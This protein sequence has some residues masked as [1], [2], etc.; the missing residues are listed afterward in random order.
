MAAPVTKIYQLSTLGFDVVDKQLKSIAKD[1]DAIKKAKKSAEGGLTAA[2]DTGD[3]DG[4]KKFREELQKLKI[5]EQELRVQRQQM[6]NEQKA[7]NI[8]RQAAIQAEKERVKGLRDASGWYGKLTTDIRELGAAIKNVQ[9][10]GDVVTFRGQQ[11]QFDAAI[12]KLQELTAAEQAFRR[13]FAADRTLVGEYTTGIVNAF[14]QMGL[15]DLIAGQVTRTQDKLNSLNNEFNELQRELKETQAAG[16]ATNSIEKQMIDN[17][18]EVI[19]LDTELSR[20][21]TDLRGVGDVGNQINASLK[22]GFSQVK[23]QLSSLLVQYLGV[24][25]AISAAQSGIQDA[26]LSSDQFTDLEIQ[27]NNDKVAADKLNTALKE[28]DTR[29]T[30]TGLQAIADV[31]L[32][33]GV[34]SENIAAVTEAIDK[35]KVAFG[36][37]FGSVEQGTETFAKLINIFFD[38]GQITG[39]RILKIGNSI[40]SLANETVASVPFLTDF[41]GRLAGLRQISSITLPDILGLGAGFEEFKQSAEVSS[42]VLLKVIPKLAADTE[43]FAEVAGLTNEEFTQ[44]INNNPAEALIRVSEAL[45]KSGK[46]I[47]TVSEALADSELGSGRIT[48]IIGT[49]GGKADIFRQRIARAGDTIQ[50]TGAIE[51]AFVKKNNNLAGSFDKLSKQASDFFASK[52]FQTALSGILAL[53]TAIIGALPVIIPLVGLLTVNWIAQ[54]AAL[55]GLRAQL[56]LYNIAIG[57]NLIAINA[58]RVANLAYLVVMF[59]VNNGLRLITAAMRLFGI[60]TTAATGPLGVLLALAGLLVTAFKAFGGAFGTSSAQLSEYNK[61]LQ[62]TRDITREVMR[63]TSEQMAQARLLVG[64]VKDVT[65]SEETRLANLKKLIDIDTVFQKA[66]VDGKINYE[67]LNEALTN[68]NNNLIKSAELE[69]IRARATRETTRLTDI[70]ITKQDIEFAIS[71]KNFKELSDEE[72]KLISDRAL[73]NTGSAFG[74]PPG[75]KEILK[76]ARDVVKGLDAQAKETTEAIQRI[77]ELYKDKT[78]DIV[79]DSKKAAEEIGGA[80]PKIVPFEVDIPKLQQDLEDLNKKINEFKGAGKD[81]DKL[82]ADRDKKQAE[83]DKLLQKQKGGRARGSKLSGEQK[84]VLKDIDAFRDEELARLNESFLRKSEFQR[85]ETNLLVESEDGRL[86]LTRAHQNVLI[87][88]EEKFLLEQLEINTNAIDKKL[89]FLKGANAEERKQIAELNLEKI[90]I[91]QETNNKIFEI[92]AKLLKDNLETEVKNTIEIVTR[93]KEDPTVSEPDKAQAQLDADKKIL[94][95]TIEFNRQ[96]DLLEKDRNNVSKKNQ[97]DR[98]RE[99][100]VRAQNVVDDE[101]KLLD[102]QLIEIRRAGERQSTQYEINFVKLRN[103]ILNNDRLTASQRK[104]ALEK[105]AALQNFTI[106]SNE[107]VQLQK[108]FKNIEEQYKKGLKTEQEFLDAKLKLEKKAEEQS[109]AQKEVNKQKLTAPNVTSLQQLFSEQL[110]RAFGFEDDSEQARVLAEVVAQGYDLATQAM[111]SFFDAEQQ[112]IQSSLDLQLERLEIEKQQVIA[113]A[114]SQEE[115]ASLE[116]QFEAKKRDAQRK[117]GEELKKTKRSEAKIA[118]AVELANIAVQ[119]SQYPFPASLII[120]ALLSGLAFGRYGLRIAEINAQ[121]F[122]KGGQPGK[123]KG[124]M[125]RAIS[126]VRRAIDPASIQRD[127]VPTRGGKFK[128][129]QHRDGGTPFHFKGSRFEAEVDELAIIR[130]KGAPKGRKFKVEGTQ[131]QIASAINRIGGGIDFKPGANIKKF[132]TG[133]AIGQSLQ[134]P[135]FKPASA[136]ILNANNNDDV[137]DALNEQRE[138]IKELADAQSRR[139]DRIQVQQVTRTVTNAQN[140]QV[141]QNNVGTL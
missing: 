16:L 132:E 80:T 112:R 99:R 109:K 77:Q 40:R 69:A 122:E 10:Q 136:A 28:L 59:L 135:I 22:S 62:L 43:K 73:A 111:N 124:R 55:L 89:A 68:Y 60:T 118:L 31:A 87:D 21:R 130:T 119:A 103:T 92:R 24:Q 51:D 42:T 1:F 54:N 45:V 128:G 3:I 36:K 127:E 13:Q 11:F 2:I 34:T 123:M 18:N 32:K 79:D 20:L 84:D 114:E 102:A 47:T 120:G 90:K 46:D 57:F 56:I 72:L 126:S 134:A 53:L 101:K 139:I 38:D 48:T 4:A 30:L 7:E 9:N 93:V 82:I 70:Q 97:D 65:I 27:L 83:L 117:A 49:L 116:K 104:K 5:A 107:L 100:R 113:R 121:K 115:I 110:S 23:G 39:D 75:E 138:M 88:E 96:M 17:R 37:D 58:L 26:K 141:R 85:R 8:A 78:K 12:K 108:E 106:L 66:L 137:V 63:A 76:A 35:T 67:K 6:L 41:S 19:K 52:G 33:A 95:L 25:A 64:V 50:E 94:D 15:D 140:K 29:T 105:L 86:K 133:G 129:R 44:L 98:E 91:E 74:G 71:S 81:L 61:K 14:K 125:S 131:E